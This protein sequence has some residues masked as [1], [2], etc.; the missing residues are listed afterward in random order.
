[1]PAVASPA[2][3]ASLFAE[4]RAGLGRHRFQG[5]NF[6]LPTIFKQQAA[7]M[8]ALPQDLD[9]A[10]AEARAY[11]TD[12]AARLTLSAPRVVDGR[13]EAT[14][15]IENRAGHKLPTA[16]PSRR[17]WLHA[18]VTDAEGKTCFESGAVGPDGAI[19][20]NDNDESPEKYEPHH[21]RIERPDQVQIYESIL[22]DKNGAV[23]RSHLS[24][25][26]SSCST[27]PS[28]IAGARTWKRP[29]A[30]NRGPSCVPSVRR[31]QAPTNSWSG[32]S[33]RRSRRHVK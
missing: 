16:Y 28:A 14:V 5:G 20:G 12:A 32:Q 17:V 27:S 11:L 10:V 19:A 1:M 3:I 4:P 15:A 24:K 26:A 13:L 31:S 22:G 9:R 6:I 7:A 25:S 8:P 21:A 23:T 2:P 30:P 29:P 18:T 33:K